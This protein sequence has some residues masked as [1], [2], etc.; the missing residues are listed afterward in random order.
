MKLATIDEQELKELYKTIK[1]VFIAIIITFISAC[2]SFAL[3]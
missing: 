2:V 3:R 1:L